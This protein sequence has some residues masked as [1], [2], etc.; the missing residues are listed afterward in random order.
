MF[1]LVPFMILSIV[2]Y[3]GTQYDICQD[4]LKEKEN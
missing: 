2:T 1:E 4:V 3:I